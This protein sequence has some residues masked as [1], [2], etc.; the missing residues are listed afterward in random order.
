[1]L[2]NWNLLSTINLINILDIA[3]RLQGFGWDSSFNKMLDDVLVK[4]DLKE[5][6]N[7]KISECLKLL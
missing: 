5:F 1:M 2:E 4:K 3:S 7:S 6:K